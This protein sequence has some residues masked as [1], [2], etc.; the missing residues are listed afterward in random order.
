MTKFEQFA[1]EKQ[2]LLGVS[3]RTVEWYHESLRWLNT[4][5]P[6]VEELKDAVLR[7][8]TALAAAPFTNASESGL[9]P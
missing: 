8:R 1:K 3:P 4:E 2:Y 5:S 6:S 9:T 7:M